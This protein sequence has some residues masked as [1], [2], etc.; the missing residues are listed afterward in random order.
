MKR[1]A[2]ILTRWVPLTL[3]ICLLPLSKEASS[4]VDTRHQESS[5]AKAE[6]GPGK[7]SVGTKSGYQHTGIE[8]PTS[9]GA[10]L[11]HADEIKESS[12]RLTGIDKALNP[13]YDFKKRANDKVGLQ[14]GVHYA[15]LYQ[16]A[17]SSLG[18]QQAAS[19]K[20]DL[21]MQWTLLGRKT[22]YAGTL[23]GK[24]EYRHRLGTQIPPSELAQ[25]LG[26]LVT[27]AYTYSDWGLGVPILYWRQQFL[28][29]RLQVAVGKIDP[30]DFF[31]QMKLAT[32]QTGFLNGFFQVS[33]T[34]AF[35][36]QG[37]G[38][39]AGAMPTDQLYVLAGVSDANGDPTRAGFDTFFE[40][41]EYFTAAEVGYFSSY[42]QRYYDNIHVTAWHV[43]ERET[44]KTPEGWGVSASVSWLWGD[45]WL[46]FLRGGY[47]EGEAAPL[48]GAVSAGLGIRFSTHDVLGVGLG[49]GRPSDRTLN[50]EYVAELFYRLQLT[51]RLAITPDVQVIVDPPLNPDEDVIGVFGIRGRLSF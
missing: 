4:Q 3:L 44:A 46:P 27:T 13:W 5:T 15:A 34:I 7:P 36:D 33:P 38:A 35:P 25:E 1:L 48:Q 16:G 47:S 41:S 11:R 39:V 17:T 21:S 49:W 22:G 32:A 40:D 14:F 24:V 31:D 18:E 10:E 30:T 6:S 29:N 45:R 23:V 20:L 9:V 37:L 50:D 51:Q 8:G 42:E 43:D 12:F 19:G 26:A 2:Y 28:T